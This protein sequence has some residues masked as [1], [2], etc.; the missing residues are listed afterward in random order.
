MIFRALI[1]AVL[2]LAANTAQARLG[3]TAD[4]LTARYGQG[5]G[6]GT[7]VQTFHK[8]N[9]TITVWLKDGVSAAEQYQKVGGPSDDDI[10]TLLSNNAQGQTWKVKTVQ[11]TLGEMLVPT[12]ATI[13]R[14][15]VRDDGTLAYTPGGI[16]YCLTVKS[17]ALVD[18]EAAKKV[19]DD[20]AKQSSLNGF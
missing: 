3:E 7:N 2:F 16:Q 10:N 11:H 8:Q 12:V 6:V 17:K 20:K 5:T 9:W 4:Q 15:W 1:I 13:S 19:A 14:C 18:A